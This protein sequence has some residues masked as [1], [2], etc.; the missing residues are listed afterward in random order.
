MYDF[1]VLKYWKGKLKVV[2]VLINWIVIEKGIVGV[3]CEK[4]WFN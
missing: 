3:K 4:I 1:E 2:I